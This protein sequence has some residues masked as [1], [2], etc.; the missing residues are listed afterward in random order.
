MRTTA[1]ILRLFPIVLLVLVI[2]LP[3]TPLSADGYRPES[4]WS[5]TWHT[6]WTIMEYGGINSYDFDMVFT[7]S[8]SHVTGISDYYG[9]QFTGTTSGNE[10]TGT[11]SNTWNNP[12][13]HPHINGEVKLTL[14]SS[15]TAFSGIFKG[16]YH[17]QW[18]DRF[19]VEGSRQDSITP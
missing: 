19:T 3:A 17:W 10:L 15:G 16:Q 18:D 9:W 11:W 14:N 8:G 5:G 12:Q 4:N 13:L 7:Q 6:T 1:F 2:L